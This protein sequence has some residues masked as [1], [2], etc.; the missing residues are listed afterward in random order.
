M[1]LPLTP[2]VVAQTTPANT[3][4]ARATATV[5]GTFAA[6]FG[7]KTFT[8][9]AQA[10]AQY[11][12][13][14]AFDYAIFQGASSGLSVTGSQT[15]DGSVHSNGAL[16]FGGS[17]SVAGVCTAGQGDTAS[18]EGCSTSRCPHGNPARVLSI[19]P[20]IVR[21]PQGMIIVE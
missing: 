13:G 3:V 18:G 15:V 11:G 5:P 19:S 7:Y 14:P 4:L 20:P 16:S 8:I 17:S 2:Q 9:H 12:S 1:P 10:V 6:L 21:L